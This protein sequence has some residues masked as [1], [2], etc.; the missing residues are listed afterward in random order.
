[1]ANGKIDL[2]CQYIENSKA[3]NYPI[4]ND[5]LCES[6]DFI[7]NG[8]LKMLAVILQQAGET[9]D[10]QVNIY[11]RILAGAQS[12]FTAEDFLRM[13]LSIEI[14]DFVNFTGECKELSLK[15]NFV[16][17]AII[18]IGLKEKKEEQFRLLAGFCEA[19]GI[20]KEEMRYLAMMAKAI[21]EMSE[22]AYV[23]AYE[24]K[25]DSIPDMVFQGYRC[26]IAKSCICSNDNLIIFQSTCAEQVNLR[27]LEK[28]RTSNAPNVKLINVEINLNEYYMCFNRKA[29]VILESCVIR[30]GNKHPI[31]FDNCEKVEIK[32]TEFMD[33]NSRTLQIENLGSLCIEGCKFINCKYIYDD[34]DDE[35]IYGYEISQW[36]EL[37]GFIYSENS[38]KNGKIYIENSLFKNCGGIN[39]WDVKKS[40][41]ISNVKCNVSNCKFIDCWHS[42][43]MHGYEKIDEDSFARTMFTDSSEAI[44]C[45]YENS[46]RFS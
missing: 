30:S 8:Y 43:A 25:A 28:I 1:M 10:A 36:M 5:C 23:D 26:L 19:L 38:L 46:A 31:T 9:T 4:K 24:V 21:L 2:L 13:A 6:T 12:E 22:S 29:S 44:N 42:C 16:L 7:K 39:E 32:N 34:R 41:F 40:A 17:D 45:V 15:Y 18:L 14:E 37:G 3:K 20:T 33:F 11:K 27:M 35:D